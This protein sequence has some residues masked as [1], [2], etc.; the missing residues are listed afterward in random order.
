M[1]QN[2]V[3]FGT[4]SGEIGLKPDFSIKSKVAVPKLKFWNGLGSFVTKK[5]EPDDIDVVAFFNEQKM[6]LLGIRARDVFSKYDI[7]HIRM[8]YHTDIRFV[9]DNREN[10]KNYWCDWYGFS[11][12]KRP[13]EALIY[14]I[15]HKSVLL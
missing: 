12:S 11:R 2:S 10:L 15:G 13:K 9:P 6:D 5:P 1:F 14:A 7:P 4:C 8:Q 3:S